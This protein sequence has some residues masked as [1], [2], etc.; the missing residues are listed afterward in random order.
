MSH[1]EVGAVIVGLVG[2]F[3]LS[4]WLVGRLLDRS[5]PAPVRPDRRVPARERWLLGDDWRDRVAPYLSESFV[6]GTR[7]RFAVFSVTGAD[8]EKEAAATFERPA[9]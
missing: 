5:V 2:L 1:L 7:T 4:V 8:P 3:R 6:R 9:A